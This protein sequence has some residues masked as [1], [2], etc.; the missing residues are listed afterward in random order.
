[1]A[2]TFEIT[3]RKVLIDEEWITVVEREINGHRYQFIC[4]PDGRGVFASRWDD[5]TERF[6]RVHHIAPSV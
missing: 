5:K 2:A 6:V 3:A 4:I 1:M